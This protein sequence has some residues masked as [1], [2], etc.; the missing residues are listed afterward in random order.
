VIILEI[1]ESE[2]IF[3]NVIHYITNTHLEKHEKRK[4]KEKER[5]SKDGVMGVMGWITSIKLILIS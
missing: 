4:K 5:K 3:K 1:K 2:N